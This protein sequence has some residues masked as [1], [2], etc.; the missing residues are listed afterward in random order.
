MNKE[1]SEQRNDLVEQ[2]TDQEELE[3][4]VEQKI[5]TK[6]KEPADQEQIKTEQLGEAREELNKTYEEQKSNSEEV[7]ERRKVNAEEFFD[8]AKSKEENIKLPVTGR[9]AEFVSNTGSS[10]EVRDKIAERKVS[11]VVKALGEMRG[12]LENIK[13]NVKVILDVGA[14]WGE[15]LKK[16]VEELEAEKGIA[17]DKSTVLSKKVKEDVEGKLTMVNGD[18]VEEMKCLKNNSIDLSMATALLQVVNKDEKVKILKE[19]RRVS[20]LVV[21]VDE[22]KRDGLGGFRDLFMNKLYNAGMGKYEVLK[23]EEWKEVIKEAG[24]IVVEEIFNKFGKNDFVVVLK[25]M[26]EKSEE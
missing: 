8:E 22:L 12:S 25:K 18:A 16:L 14:G 6:D 3:P 21:V 5:E 23:E 20:E 4:E 19:M 15:N 26:E 11:E 24:L 9:T 13:E 17:I 1:I 10:Q 2:I 7:E